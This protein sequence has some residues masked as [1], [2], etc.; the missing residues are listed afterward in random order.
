MLNT[1]WKQEDS[2][3]EEE[4]HQQVQADA[5]GQLKRCRQDI[6]EGR[7]RRNDSPNHSTHGTCNYCNKPGH[8]YRE[9]L[10]RISDERRKDNLKE[11]SSSAGMA[12]YA[13]RATGGAG[14]LKYWIVDSGASDTWRRTDHG[15]RITGTFVKVLRLP[16][17][18][19]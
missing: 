2:C 5:P 19:A 11:I 17:L 7:H 9:C 10:K 14:S 6:I 8:Y 13:C 3:Q 15:F 12:V 1:D 4:L 18:E 16:E